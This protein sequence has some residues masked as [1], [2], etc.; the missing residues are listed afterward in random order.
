VG[1]DGVHVRRDEADDA[2]N[3]VW[4]DHEGIQKNLVSHRSRP[5]PFVGR[6]PADCVE[7]HPS[8]V[9]L[10]EETPPLM[11]T[12]RHEV[13]GPGAIVER[14]VAR[15]GA[16]RHWT[17]ADVGWRGNRETRPEGPA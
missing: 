11:R 16:I 15:G 17:G 9:H 4:H 7:D 14:W 12:D 8:T 5:S 10:P 3:V 6:N 1:R 13:R 2:V